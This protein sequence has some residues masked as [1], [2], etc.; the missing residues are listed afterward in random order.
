MNPQTIE[1]P[2][3]LEEMC[4]AFL[5]D[6]NGV[7]F[8]LDGMAGCGKSSQIAQNFMPMYRA[9]EPNARVRF[10]GPTHA[11]TNELR[12]KLIQW[13]AILKY[14]LLPEDC[15]T[16]HR[17]T[18]L[19]PMTDEGA[20]QANLVRRL[21]HIG[22]ALECDLLV[23]D[24]SG[25]VDPEVATQ[26]QFLVKSRIV[27]K[28]MYMGDLNQLKPVNGKPVIVPERREKYH[29]I[30]KDTYRAAGEDIRDH[31][32][33]LY[34]IIDAGK[35]DALRY[36]IKG[37][38]NVSYG[39]LPETMSTDERALAFTHKTVQ[40]INARIRGRDHAEQGDIA[41]SRTTKTYY[42]ILRVGAAENWFMVDDVRTLERLR[43]N[44]GEDPAF[45][46]PLLNERSDRYRVRQH[47]ASLPGVQL[48]QLQTVSLQDGDWVD[49]DEEPEYWFVLYGSSRHNQAAKL[50]QKEGIRHNIDLCEKHGLM[51][52]E[53]TDWCA[54]NWD[55]DDVKA[56][57]KA[58]RTFFALD[59]TVMAL[60]APFCI[61]AHQAQGMTI[62]RVYVAA[63]DLRLAKVTDQGGDTYARLLYVAL[64]RASQ[65]L[66]LLQDDI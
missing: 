35:G 53:L 10:L 29:Y 63:E 40:A 43:Q 13:S 42:R 34:N 11:A 46:A 48:M 17:Y 32:R 37:S 41:Y 12:D 56:K 55:R 60:D 14:K 26:L 7:R 21:K 28:I 57:R 50:A 59:R 4:R 51:D 9:M 33:N 61:T 22:E 19:V 18:G 24:E 62:P 23:V 58:W 16:T 36:T 52:D 65:K 6:E 15:M 54:D 39:V 8:L 45:S 47:C 25:M 3:G 5:A 66:V 64:S 44:P 20:I 38:E 27:K 2:P 31:V 1:W 30:I 49:E